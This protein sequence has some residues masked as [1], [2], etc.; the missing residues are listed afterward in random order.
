MRQLADRR[1]G[2]ILQ[3]GEN[4]MFCQACGATVGD[5][6]A[7]CTSCG[8]PIV[9]YSVGGTSRAIAAAGVSAGVS[10]DYAGFWLRFVASL[11]DGIILA[12]PMAILYGLLVAT[13]IPAIV[14]NQG[15]PGAIMAT[16]LP[17]LLLFEFLA[18]VA[19]WLYFALMESSSWQATLGKKALGLYVTDTDGN[20]V[21]FARATGRFFAKMISGL[22]LLIGYIM[23]GFTEK[24]Q[25]LHDIIASCLVMRKS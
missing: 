10:A 11:L 1:C 24:K 19:Q 5:G 14:R 6:I 16:I 9:G 22:T 20:R 15:D 21:S 3:E 2:R 12:V 8:R 4:S 17:R 7:F 23:A 13:A 25:A 18:F